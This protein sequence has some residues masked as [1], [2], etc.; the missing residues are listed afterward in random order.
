M[1]HLR[2]TKLG[3]AYRRYA[4]Q[5]GRLLEW[6]GLGAQHELKWILRDIN[7]EIQR[8]EAVGL[9]GVNGAGK[10]TLLKLIAG[11][12]RPTTGQITVNGRITALL[13]LGMGFHADF[14]GRENVLMSA[15]I[16]GIPASD[17][18]A[19]RHPHR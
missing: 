17:R 5:S 11:T 14:T 18:C 12:A 3:K 16:A 10:S 1:G 4:R 8:G 15:R 13:E 19:A 9:I 2:V 6:L 7:F